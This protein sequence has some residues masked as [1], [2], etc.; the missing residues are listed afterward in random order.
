[1]MKNA[2]IIRT[3]CPAPPMQARDRGPHG[4]RVCTPRRRSFAAV[5]KEGPIPLNGGPMQRPRMTRPGG[6]VDR[7]PI[8]PQHHVPRLPVVPVDV[9]GAGGVLVQS[10]QK[11]LALARCQSQNGASE[12]RAHEEAIAQRLGVCAD[13]WVHLL[14]HE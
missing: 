5:E 6:T 10:L 1:M 12:T 2:G 7:A 14:K 13:H 9:G 4:A 8:V 3:V 11:R